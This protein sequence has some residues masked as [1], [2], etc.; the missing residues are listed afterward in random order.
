MGGAARVGQML[1]TPSHE[2]H[3][4]PEEI[5]ACVGEPV[6]VAVGL[7]GVRDPIEE[8]HVDE[9]PQSRRER[10]PWDAEVARELA[11]APDSEERFAQD[12]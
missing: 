6:L 9:H 11:E 10:G 4:C 8:A 3:D 12:Q 5:A 1:V 2:H 7:A